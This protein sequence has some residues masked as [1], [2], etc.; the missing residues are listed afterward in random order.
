MY[1]IWRVDLENLVTEV[2]LTIKNCYMTSNYVIDGR[3]LILDMD[4][5]GYFQGNFCKI[6][7]IMVKKSTK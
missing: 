6:V 2:Q 1:I 4:S 5:E 7:F 3:L